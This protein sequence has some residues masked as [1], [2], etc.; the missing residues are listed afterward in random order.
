MLIESKTVSWIAG[1]VCGLAWPLLKTQAERSE[2][3]QQQ[4]KT[5]GIPEAE[6]VW[7]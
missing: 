4:L 2:W 1:K 5:L 6:H 3:F 7:G